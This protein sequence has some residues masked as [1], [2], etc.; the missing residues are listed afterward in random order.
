MG[1]SSESNRV[2]FREKW[3]S[4]AAKCK[5]S[6]R[7]R[8]KQLRCREEGK[9]SLSGLNRLIASGLDAFKIAPF[10]VPTKVIHEPLVDEVHKKFSSWIYQVFN[11]ML[12]EVEND[13]AWRKQ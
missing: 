12:C 9:V 8:Q 2:R 1:G 6:E 4:E 11:L 10:W 3:K 13:T 5:E 7:E